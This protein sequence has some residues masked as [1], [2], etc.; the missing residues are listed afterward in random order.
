MPQPS[1]HLLSCY[2]LVELGDRP[3]VVVEDGNLTPGEDVQ[4]QPAGRHVQAE[5]GLDQARPGEVVLFC[6][7]SHSINSAWNS[8]SDQRGERLETPSYYS[9]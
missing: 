9:P 6:S 7:E 8:L 2:P 5:A 3:L 1:T 4:H